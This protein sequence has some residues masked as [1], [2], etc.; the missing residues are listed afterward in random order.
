M[1][2]LKDIMDEMDGHLKFIPHCMGYLMQ[3]YTGQPIEITIANALEMTNA[4][5]DLGLVIFSPILNTHYL[6]VSKPRER[7]FWMAFDLTL[8]NTLIGWEKPDLEKGCLKFQHSRLFMIGA[9][10]YEKSLGCQIE[11]EWANSHGVG[12]YEYNPLAME[13]K[14]VKCPK[15]RVGLPNY[16]DLVKTK[17]SK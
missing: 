7:G 10:G 3:P 1:T 8:L 6:H 9:P 4:L 13:G 17:E 14:W 11:L 5:M 15:A 16:L 12:C 2:N